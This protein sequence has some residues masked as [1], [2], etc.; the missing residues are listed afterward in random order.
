MHV[1]WFTSCEIHRTKEFLII[2]MTVFYSVTENGK[3]IF[4]FGNKCGTLII[5]VLPVNEFTPL[6]EPST[7]NITL[8]EKVPESEISYSFYN[9][10]AYFHQY[11]SLLL[12]FVI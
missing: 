9:W 3:N 11:L 2:K 6:I 4:Q 1:S 8:P 10:A 5:N 7:Q 12:L